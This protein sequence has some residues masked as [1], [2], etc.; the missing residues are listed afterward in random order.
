M[1]RFIFPIFL[2]VIAAGCAHKTIHPSRGEMT[3]LLKEADTDHDDKI[4]V[5]DKPPTFVLKCDCGKKL[6]VSGAYE[7]SNLL[8]EL[9]LASLENRREIEIARVFE[10]P[11]SRI[12]RSIRERY[13]DN[14]VRQVT[15]ASLAQVLVDSKLPNQKEFY[16]YIPEKD[17]FALQKFKAAAADVSLK[18]KI[19]PLPD[20]LDINYMRSIADRHGLLYLPE[21]YVVPGG[22]FNE[23]YGWDSYF[24]SL[25]IIQDG[26]PELARAM[27]DNFIYE[28]ENYGKILNGNRTYYLNRSQPPFLTALIIA[29]DEAQPNPAWRRKATQAAIQEYNEVWMKGDRLTK[30]GLN[31]YYGSDFGVPPEVEP[32]HF[33]DVLKPIAARHKVSIKKLVERY[34]EGRLADPQLKELLAHDRAVRES[35][36]DTTYRWKVKDQDRAADFVTVDLNAL[37]YK[38]EVD[39]AFLTGDSEWKARA[40]KR[41]ALMMRYMWDEKQ[42]IFFDYNWREDY[43]SPFVSATAFYPLWA[44][45]LDSARAKE[46]IHALVAR[47]EAPGGL[48]SNDEASLKAVRADKKQRQWDYPSGWAPHQ[49]IAWRALKNY[50]EI[51]TMDRLIYKWL[52]MITKN[53]HDYNGT[54]P[55]KYDVVKRSHAVFAEYGNVGT[56]FAYITQEGFGWMNAAYQ[57]GLAELPAPLRLSLEKL[58]PPEE[59]K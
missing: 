20:R 53:A 16:L 27:A 49:M 19:V 36:H 29:I 38:Y 5:L 47:L 40:E 2:L 58:I 33:D 30:L 41:K 28:I 7:L 50:G 44:G 52:F 21:P 13:W 10:N 59:L 55:E 4:T 23:M 45:V 17:V 12:S 6:E 57:V 25:G 8:Q 39:L 48:L 46:S 43:R 9:K 35:G 56:D 34:N 37:L 24:E 31:R 18:M 3:R 42:K 32:G 11:V 22:R 15:P 54:V 26:R 14:L 1:L 51:A